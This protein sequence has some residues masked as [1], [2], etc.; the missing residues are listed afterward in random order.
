MWH[1]ALVL[2]VVAILS[3]RG[4][5]R[6][7]QVHTGSLTRVDLYERTILREWMMVALILAGVWWHGSS[8]FTV[9][10]NRWRSLRDFLRHGAIGVGFLGVTIVFGSVLNRGGD[11]SGTRF[12]LPHG[13]T[14]L[15]VWTALALTAG[16]CEEAIYRGYLQRQFIAITKSVPAGIVLSAILFGTGHLYQGI[17]YASQIAVL[18]ALAG[19]LA[20]W[21]KSVRP[22]M[23][24]HAV[25]DILGGLVQHS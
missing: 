18:G 2:A 1:L 15:L 20:Y 8:A 6:L 14:E 7:G 11:Q 22:G 9:L 24:A 5:T 25:Q 3:Y 19:I 13:R 12:M 21:C 17:R 23:I 16:I 10:G 4:Q